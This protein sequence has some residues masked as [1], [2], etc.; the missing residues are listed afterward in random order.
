[1]A[2]AASRA[3]RFSPAVVQ[4]I[5]QPDALPGARC[6]IRESGG[7]P[8]WSKIS[9][10]PVATNSPSRPRFFDYLEKNVHLV[11]SKLP[12]RMLCCLTIYAQIRTKAKKKTD[13]D[14]NTKTA[15]SLFVHSKRLGIRLG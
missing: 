4:H 1:M 8:S 13:Q 11:K 6:R 7:G 14:L 9:H 3:A 2:A 5:L 12:I 10:R 15:L